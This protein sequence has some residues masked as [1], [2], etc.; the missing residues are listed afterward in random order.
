MAK[1]EP[2]EGNESTA[3]TGAARSAARESGE[4]GHRP[5]N[6]ERQQT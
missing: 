5:P 6:D 3:S 2:I 1:I 4:H